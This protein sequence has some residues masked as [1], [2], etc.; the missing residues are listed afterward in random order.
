MTSMIIE[1]MAALLVKFESCPLPPS[2]ADEVRAMLERM[3]DEG[4]YPDESRKRTNLDWLQWLDRVEKGSALEWLLSYC[5]HQ[6]KY[7]ICAEDCPYIHYGDEC[8]AYSAGIDD[9]AH[10]LFEEKK[11]K[12]EDKA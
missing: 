2:L 6:D 1:D 10:W 9:L 7:G 3:R 4:F 11:A 5:G 8:A 12:G